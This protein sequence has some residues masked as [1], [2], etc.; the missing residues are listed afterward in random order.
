M[1]P[2]QLDDADVVLADFGEDITCEAAPDVTRAL[3]EDR[4]LE[5]EISDRRVVSR[6][7]MMQVKLGAFGT[8]AVQGTRVT[9]R[10]RGNLVCKI[11]QLLPREA[12]LFESYFLE[13]VRA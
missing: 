12:S 7:L 9:L 13:P 11:G 3:L 4:V 1:S 2:F 6:A 8:T 10:D 5:D